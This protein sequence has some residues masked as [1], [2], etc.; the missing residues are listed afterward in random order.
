MMIRRI[1]LAIS[2]FFLAFNVLLY[3]QPPVT[4][5]AVRIV[6]NRRVPEDTI[7][8]Y[9]QTKE[10]DTYDEQ[11][12]IADF[13]ALVRLKSFKDVKVEEQD[14]TKGKI[15]IFQVEEWPLIR[16]IEYVGNKSFSQ[17][18]ILEHFKN[19]KVGLTVDS[20]FDPGKINLAERSLKELLDKNGKPMGT[21]KHEIE[22]VTPTSV[23]VK[24]IVEEGPKV[25]IGQIKFTGNHVFSES[26]L[27]DTLKLTKERGIISTFKGQ[28]KYDP[29][30]LEADLDQNIRKLYQEHG[31]IKVTIGTPDAQVKEGPRGVLPVFRKTKDQFFINIP[32]VEGDQY[33]LGELH[34]KEAKVF[35]EEALLPAFGM[36]KGD[37]L[38]FTKIRD[39]LE[40]IK[41]LYGTLGYINFNYIPE[42][43]V[44]E[45]KKTVD[46]TF[47]FQEDKQYTVGHIEFAGNTRTRD[48]VLRRE[49]LLD[50][51]DVFNS[52]LLELSVLRL[53]QLG[54]FER[55]EEKDYEVKPNPDTTE[56]DVN[57][58]VKE[59][60][61]QSIGFTGGTSGI[62][63]SFVGITY[64][65]NNFRG[66]G[67][68]IEVDIT[69][70]TRTTNFLFAYTEPYFRDTRISLGLSVFNQ[71]LRFDTFNTFFGT[72]STTGKPIELFTRKTTGITLSASYP[73]WGW[74][75][76]GTSY[77][78]QNITIPEKSIAP[79]LAPFALQSLIGSTPQ[80]T[81]ESALKGIKRS[82]ITPSLI[83]N[84]TNHP[85]DP[86]RGQSLS[87]SLDIAGGPLQGDFNLLRP[88]VEY[89]YF[90][91]DRWLSHGR[92]T[93][94]M[95]LLAGFVTGYSKTPIPLFD[96]YYS[97]G[98]NLI[99]GFDIRAVSPYAIIATPAVDSNMNPIIDPSTGL[100]RVDFGVNPVGG[101]TLLNANF[102]YRIPIAGPLAVSGFFDVGTARISRLSQL[103][104]NFGTS[105]IT[106]LPNTNSV[107][108]TSTGA[109]VLFQLPVVNVPFRLIFAYNPTR[110]N[111]FI[112]N[113]QQRFIEPRKNIQF[114]IGRAF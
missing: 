11:R 83:Y 110:F 92:N 85:L 33:R 112:F 31:Y 70:G 102:E 84:T 18:D 79:G 90:H 47:L 67:Q 59:K 24:F 20:Q 13:Q 17:S 89:R 5:E 48:K 16:S 100:Q 75:R 22:P 108:R 71:R 9:L 46:M 101:D 109:E 62:S 37:V 98:E 29:L 99:R 76:L 73:L 77:T 28:D 44:D 88:N 7:K 32:I 34:I 27:R 36:K 111:D 81:I 30:K 63:G 107:L 58:K 78:I 104:R 10:G 105:V 61:Q 3:A 25:R 53:N 57:V 74:W 96:R 97:G 50:E 68:R 64:T 80:G 66:K 45:G 93:L 86:T 113:I 38:N 26:K 40:K 14:G 39:A 12:I 94:A 72:V 1:G 8:F 41:Q 51:K 55:I 4:I 103:G 23:K 114:T 95:R 19:K 54:F 43:N 91:P 60:G 21:V 106:L 56:V 35:K 52:K 65:S 69:A 87:L 15:I 2:L 82:Q 49:M 6:G 42:Q